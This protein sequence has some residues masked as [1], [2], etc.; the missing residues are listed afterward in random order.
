[1]ISPSALVAVLLAPELDALACLDAP[2]AERRRR[3]MARDAATFARGSL[4]LHLHWLLAEV[5]PTGAWVW[6]VGDAHQ[7][8]FATLATAAPG[9]HGVVPVVFGCSD[10]DDEHPA[11]WPWDL[12]RL[13][14][15]VKSARPA[16][17]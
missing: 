2:A 8:N 11:P 1:M 12:L 7:G 4:A 10:V 6:S 15:S 3:A 17:G 16:L 13:L 5:P 14:A 9:R